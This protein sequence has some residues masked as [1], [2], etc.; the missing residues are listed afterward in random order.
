MCGYLGDS[1]ENFIEDL[2]RY[3][4]GEVYAADLR[5]ECFV[6]LLNFDELEFAIIFRMQKCRHFGQGVVIEQRAFRA[7]TMQ[8]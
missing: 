6:K 7:F 3:G 2:I 1:S 5:T 4:R 8:K